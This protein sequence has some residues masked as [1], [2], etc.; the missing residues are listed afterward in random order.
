VA[1]NTLKIKTKKASKVFACFL[2]EREIRNSIVYYKD[3]AFKLFYLSHYPPLPRRVRE[4]VCYLFSQLGQLSAAPAEAPC[5]P[6]VVFHG[7]RRP[8]GSPACKSGLCHQPSSSWQ[9]AACQ[10]CLVSLLHTDCSL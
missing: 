1:R 4:L 10:D 9:K 3:S 8:L 2:G 6:E 7:S 5:P